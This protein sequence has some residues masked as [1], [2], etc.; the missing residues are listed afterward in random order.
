LVLVGLVVFWPGMVIM[1]QIPYLEI[2]RLLVVAEVAGKM[3]APVFL[4]VLV[5]QVLAR[6]QQDK[7]IL[8]ALPV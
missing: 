1:D 2:L 8:A 3:L 5:A 6:V 4:V 7:E